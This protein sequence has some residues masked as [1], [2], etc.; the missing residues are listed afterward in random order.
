MRRYECD[1]TAA[2][3]QRRARRRGCDRSGTADRDKRGQAPARRT[4]TTGVLIAVGPTAPPPAFVMRALRRDWR[5]GDCLAVR[6][7]D[8]AYASLPGVAPNSLTRRAM[9]AGADGA[10]RQCLSIRRRG[11]RER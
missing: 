3:D 10:Y 11:S 5:R 2:R 4:A 9:Q 8:E 1:G 6:H 7:D